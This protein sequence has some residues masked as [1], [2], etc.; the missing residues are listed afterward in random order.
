MKKVFLLL[1]AAALGMVSCKKDHDH[2]QAKIFKGP[3]SK[4]QHGSAW[5]WYEVDGKNKPLRLGATIDAAAMNSLDTSHSGDGGHHHE[6]MLSLL[7]PSQAKDTVPF[8]HFGLAIA[9]YP[10]LLRTNKRGRPRGGCTVTLILCH[11]P[12][13]TKLA[14]R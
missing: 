9:K 7:F 12:L 10:S 1:I 8:L 5:T 4:F 13:L 3:V 14:G 11:L 6:N 2:P